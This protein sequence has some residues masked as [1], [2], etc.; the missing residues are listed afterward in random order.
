MTYVN[1]EINGKSVDLEVLYNSPSHAE[2]CML[3]SVATVIEERLKGITCPVHGEPPIVW[4][5]GSNALR[6][7]RE[8]QGCCDEFVEMARRRV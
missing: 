8:V 5:H 4:F 1:F 2:A 7:E 6:M 3:G